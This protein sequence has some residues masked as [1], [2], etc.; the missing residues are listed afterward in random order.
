MAR[1]SKTKGRGTDGRRTGWR[2]G[3]RWLLALLVVIAVLLAAFGL[4]AF[5]LVFSSVPLPDDIDARS[6]LVFDVDGAEVGTLASELTRDDVPLDSL[7]DHVPA[8]VL[9]AEDRGFYEH[10]GISFTGIARALFTNVRAGSVQQGGSTITQQYIKNAALSPELTYRR[11]VEEAA[12][13]IKL[14]QTYSKDE[15]LGFY[16]NTIYWGRGTYGIEASSQA[17]FEIPAAELDVNQAATL[18]GI[19]ASPENFDP[20]EN[21]E[22]ADQRRRYVLEGMVDTGALTRAEADVLLAD[23]LPEVS[24]RRGINLGPNAYYLDAVRRELS[25]R[26][27]FAQGELF[28]GLRIHTEL[29]QSMQAAAQRT[30]T[31]AVVD[32]PT[33]TGAIV[34]ID[35]ATGGVRALAGGPDIGAQP[36]NTAVRSVRQVGSTFKAFTLQAFIEA[37][38]SPETRF[39][40]PAELE[41][42]DSERPISNYG[43]SSFGEQTV[44]QATASSTNT[45]YVQMQEEVGR[46]V[47][48]DAARRAGLPRDRDDEVFPTERGEGQTMRP[49]AGLTLGQDEFSP[50]ELTSAFG[51]Y[52]AEGFHV[53]PRLIVRV[54]DSQGR[55]IYTP[56]PIEEQALEVQVSRAVTDVLVDAVVAGSGRAAAL[57]DRPVAGK[58]GTTNEG[59]DVWFAGYVPQLS[60]AVWLGNLD[61]S[62]IEGDGVAGG[63]LAAPVWRT[64]MEQATADL[65]VQGFTAPSL[66]LE[67]GEPDEASCPEGYEFADPPSA[68]DEDGFFPDILIDLTDDEGRPCVEI[69]PELEPCPPGYAFGPLPEGPDEFGRVP[70]VLDEPVDFQGR[71]CVEILEDP[72]P[73][74]EPEPDDGTDPDPDS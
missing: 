35:P 28:R 17:F 3:R 73:E 13:A 65:E 45:V 14:E 51:T 4:L 20:L 41:V 19:I 6:S 70:D 43:G 64:Y 29:D 1:S 34:S 54:E 48:I 39:T 66:D 16:L 37:G 38:R 2:R 9:A 58:T 26:E 57:D 69:K 60:T 21:P 67:G 40:A 44:R 8:A 11:K 68:A 31:A 50:L 27:E 46:E 32:G 15:I 63:A 62:P 33:D 52:A 18:A 55:A 59:R 7:P 47:V 12:L 72:E 56:E 10:R 30:L 42:E 5:Y 22:R 61:N 25:A 24:E 23:G 74:P 53:Q 49:F 36:F 71:R